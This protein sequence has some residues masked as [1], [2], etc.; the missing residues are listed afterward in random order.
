MLQNKDVEKSNYKKPGALGEAKPLLLVGLALGA[1]VILVVVALN[2]S[3]TDSPNRDNPSSQSETV[4]VGGNDTNR[5]H[6]Q[7]PALPGAQAPDNV[8]ASNHVASS[9][10]TA[11]SSLA[12]LIQMLNDTTLSL[13][14]RKEAIK[15]LAQN[16]S[17][18]AIGALKT[19]LASGNQELRAAVAEGLGDC[20]SPQC[21]ALMIGML[22]DANQQVVESAIRGLG[23]QGSPEAATALTQF[24]Y[25]PQR[26]ADLRCDAALAL[27][28]V[29]QPG[30]FA[31]LS[32][33]AL[34][35]PDEGIVKQVLNAI[36]S[37]D[38]GETRGFFESYLRSPTASGELKVEA[39]ESLY[40]AKGDSTS[41]LTTLVS[42]A[43][44]DIRVAAAWAMSATDE[45]GNGGGQLMAALQAET[46]PDVRLRLYQA[47]RNQSGFDFD[48]ALSA[49]QRESDL[50]ARVASL[51]LL[52]SMIQGGAT[53]EVQNYFDNTAA[54]ELTDI[55]LSGDKANQRMSAFIAL[56]R[57]NNDTSV[58]AIQNLSQQA[59]DPRIQES[60]KR[61]LAT[62]NKLNGN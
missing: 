14:Q 2:K 30:V 4:D 34:T 35:I 1:G 33:A 5:Q 52:A 13:D 19:V 56:V 12:R 32:Q 29:N 59:T 43:D 17:P 40:R 58:S 24:L 38:I 54:R 53:P 57:A 6:L 50:D 28:N 18:E 8:A 62:L 44:S 10:I 51:N 45:P 46:D 31:T 37:R 9:E 16:G 42:D 21:T 15:A 22:N 49:I 3:S 39:V 41:F 11:E 61:Y 36:G 25:D 55:A 23:R 60:A 48:Q 47:L 7:D 27:G 26:S 20:A